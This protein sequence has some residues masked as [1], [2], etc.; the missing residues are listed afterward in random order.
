MHGPSPA[1][2]PDG[3]SSTTCRPR[4]DR[5][6]AIV[7]GAGSGIGA[8]VA[9]RLATSAW[10]LVLTGRRAAP[11]HAVADGADAVVIPGDVRSEDHAHK[12]VA[13][14]LESYGRLDGLVLNAGAEAGGRVDQTSVDDWQMMLDTNVTGPFLL[15][16]AALP[17]LRQCRGSVVAIGSIA[18]AVAGPESAAYSVS[19]AALVRLMLSIAVDF[20]PLGV[21]ANA[22]NPGWIRTDMADAELA[23]SLGSIGAD[24]DAVYGQVT[25]YVPARRPGTP[26]EVA[27]AVAWLLSADASY[28]NGTVLTV[29][30]GTSIVDAGMLAF[31]HTAPTPE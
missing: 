6:V 18:A 20:G 1:S 30:G 25:R 29:D 8:Q 16:R 3:D 10:R 23:A 24:L 26:D 28:V 11:L 22:V 12:L 21:R 4:A 17:Q 27:A 15:C 31:D 7:T 19:K 2:G 14:A 13:A 5:P 9:T